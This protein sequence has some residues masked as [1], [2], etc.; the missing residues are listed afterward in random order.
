MQTNQKTFGIL[1]VAYVL[2]MAYQYYRYTLH[3]HPADTFGAT[4]MASYG[5]ATGWSCLALVERRW[6]MKAI[7]AL[8]VLQLGFASCYYFPV[9]FATRHGRFWDWAEATVF[10]L[11]IVWAGYRSVAQLAAVRRKPSQVQMA[12]LGR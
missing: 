1:A 9:V 4:E 8:C 11:L 5:V 3:E 12:P 7:L 6:A 2:S 10:I